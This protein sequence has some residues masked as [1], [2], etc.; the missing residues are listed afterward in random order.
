MNRIYTA[1]EVCSEVAMGREETQKGSG[2]LLLQ[3]NIPESLERGLRAREAGPGRP[4]TNCCKS[5]AGL[6]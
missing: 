3:A 4:T 1:F 6:R 2:S 5:S